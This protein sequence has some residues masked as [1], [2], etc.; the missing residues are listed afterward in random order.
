MEWHRIRHVPVE[1]HEHRLVG[2]VSYRSLMRLVSEDGP[3]GRATATIPAA[4]ITAADQFRLEPR[5]ANIQRIASQQLLA[6]DRRG[7]IPA[8]GAGYVLMPLYQAK[9]DDECFS[10]REVGWA[11]SAPAE[12][13]ASASLGMPERLGRPVGD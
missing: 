9:G 7:E 12:L 1:D 3:D 4:E 8:P 11:G 13:P 6:R 10:A 5:F 2:L